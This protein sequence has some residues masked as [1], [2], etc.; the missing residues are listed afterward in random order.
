MMTLFSLCP[1]PYEGITAPLENKV[2]SREKR[3]S[4]TH[5]PY[6]SNF[7]NIAI[8][9][10]RTCIRQDKLFLIKRTHRDN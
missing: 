6:L 1:G 7:N 4:K 5:Y 10:K 3:K 9:D 8:Q 2:P